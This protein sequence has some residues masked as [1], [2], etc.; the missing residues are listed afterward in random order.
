MVLQPEKKK[1]G[2]R[3]RL[4]VCAAAYLPAIRLADLLL[5]ADTCLSWLGF[6]IGRR[7]V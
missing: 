5:Y 7:S 3:R 1:V 6:V 4:V 2:Q